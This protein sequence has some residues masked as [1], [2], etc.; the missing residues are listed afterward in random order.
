[1]ESHWLHQIIEYQRILPL[2]QVGVKQPLRTRF[3]RPQMGAALLRSR[4]AH[5]TIGCRRG[6]ALAPRLRVAIHFKLLHRQEPD[7]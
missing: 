4:G 6:A 1:M 2:A 7:S 3:A 5:V